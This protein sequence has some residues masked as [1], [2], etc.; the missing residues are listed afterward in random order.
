MSGGNGS[1][2]LEAPQLEPEPL[3]DKDAS[4]DKE[5]QGAA[6]ET[7]AALPRPPALAGGGIEEGRDGGDHGNERHTKFRWLPRGIK[8]AEWI[9]ILFTAVTALAAWAGVA[10]NKG[11]LDALRVQVAG[12]NETSRQTER[13]L[14]LQAEANAAIGF[15][16]AKTD[17]LARTAHDQEIVE[18]R[19]WLAPVSISLKPFGADKYTVLALFTNTGHAPAFNVEDAIEAVP[20]LT[21]DR[22]NYRFQDGNIYVTRPPLCGTKPKMQNLGVIDRKSVV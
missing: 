15:Q 1:D 3:A 7:Q 19:A 4:E 9:M 21:L 2:G 16:G 22:M 18:N 11:Q 6:P 17:L 8:P 5:R 14:A 20:L 10:V 12:S 13:Q